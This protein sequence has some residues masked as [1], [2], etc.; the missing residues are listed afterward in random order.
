MTMRPFSEHVGAIR[1]LQR[2]RDILLD[3]AGSSAAPVKDADAVQYLLH[4]EG[5]QAERG[6]VEQDELRLPIR[7]AAD[8]EHLL[9]AARQGA[10]ELVAPLGEP[11]KH[12][13]HVLEA[14]LRGSPRARSI[15]P[16]SR[17]SSTVRLRKTC[18][19]SATGRCRDCRSHAIQAADRPVLEN[20]A[21]GAR[22][23]NA[24]NGADE[25]DL[26]APLARR[27]DDLALRHL[28]ADL[29]QRRRV[30]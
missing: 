22:N 28:Q 6:L 3:E 2:H 4:H 11:R 16:I 10:G 5:R 29:R 7:A 21:A 14:G 9:L 26:P 8:G 27:C 30:A 15:A 19:P 12:A 18:R 24:G 23:F 20:D 1:D 13:E 25:R 17:F